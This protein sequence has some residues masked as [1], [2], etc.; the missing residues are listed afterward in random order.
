MIPP[1][2]PAT[3]L[4]PF[5]GLG[6][7]TYPATLDEVRERFAFND[8]RQRRLDRFSAWMADLSESGLPGALWVSGSYLSM[9]PDPSDVD[10][11]V[12]IDLE[13]RVV[14]KKILQDSHPL[15]TWQDVTAQYPRKV[16][17]RKLQ[18]FGGAV[19]AH[20]AIDL[21]VVRQRWETDWSTDY[22][23]LG[24]PTGT[25]KGFLEVAR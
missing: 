15:W 11:V 21:P 25:R 23:E 9:K 2:D 16:T 12:V 8:Q 14:A 17:L 22:D 5:R 13:D 20:Y 24:I 1:L 18:P 6:Q 4:L 3:G 7:S 19:D 10:V